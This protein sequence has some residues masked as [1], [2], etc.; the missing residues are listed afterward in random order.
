M[1]IIKTKNKPENKKVSLIFFFFYR[2]FRKPDSCK[3]HQEFRSARVS[4]LSHIECFFLPKQPTRSEKKIVPLIFFSFFRLFRKPDSFEI[5]QE[6]RS[7]KVSYLSHTE[8]LFVSKQP[9]RPSCV[10]LCL[11]LARI[12]NLKGKEDYVFHP[13]LSYLLNSY[14]S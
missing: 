6:L 9:T 2:F 1:P 4:Y 12:Y 11:Y 10:S 7:A 8:C 3:I 14:M 13:P 5:L